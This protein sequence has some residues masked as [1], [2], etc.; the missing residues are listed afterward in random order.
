MGCVAVHP[1]QNS[2]DRPKLWGPN[3]GPLRA[4]VGAEGCTLYV[5]ASRLNRRHFTHGG[6]N[7]VLVLCITILMELAE[8]C[9]VT[10]LFHLKHQ[11]PTEVIWMIRGVIYYVWSDMNDPMLS[12]PHN[13]AGR[14]ANLWYWLIIWLFGHLLEIDYKK[15][16]SLGTRCICL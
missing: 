5:D 10:N 13:G 2:L 1:S 4:F 16:I 7:Q 15:S 6:G 12:S 11:S 9:I 14:S 8:F 3:F